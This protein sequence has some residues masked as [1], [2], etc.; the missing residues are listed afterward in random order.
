MKKLYN[1]HKPEFNNFKS[2]IFVFKI[3]EFGRMIWN[4][5]TLFFNQKAF[6]NVNT[7]NL[8]IALAFYGQTD[9]VHNFQGIICY[10]GLH[11]LDPPIIDLQI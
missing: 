5:R 11:G 4:K 6:S 7:L 8:M 3:Q 1:V 2:P 10:P 9:I